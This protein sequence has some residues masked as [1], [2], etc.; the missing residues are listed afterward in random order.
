VSESGRST[1]L[2]DM[3]YGFIDDVSEEDG[4]WHKFRLDVHVPKND[5][6]EG[7]EEDG[8]NWISLVLIRH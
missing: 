4:D 2:L 5:K 3:L 6:G 8:S 7:E 1:P